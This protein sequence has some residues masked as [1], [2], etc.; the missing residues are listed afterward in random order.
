MFVYPSHASWN[1][2][3]AQ[4]DIARIINDTEIQERSASTHATG[5]ESIQWH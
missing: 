1:N 5:M 3:R 4:D 2:S